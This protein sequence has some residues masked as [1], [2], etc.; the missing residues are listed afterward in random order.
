MCII[1]DIQYILAG[2]IMGDIYYLFPRTQIFCF[3]YRY[4]CPYSSVFYK[5]TFQVKKRKH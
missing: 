3:I 5:V 1:C 4:Y 2:M